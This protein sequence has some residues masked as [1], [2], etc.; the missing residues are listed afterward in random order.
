ENAQGENSAVIKI[1]EAED[2]NA[3]EP[4]FQGTL[5]LWNSYTADKLKVQ[6]TKQLTGDGPS[7]ASDED[8]VFSL[9]CKDPGSERTITAQ[10]TIRGAGN[11][12]FATA[13]APDQEAVEIPVGWSCMIKEDQINRYDADVKVSFEGATL[14][15][16]LTDTAGATAAFKIAGVPDSTQN[17]TVINDYARKR[18]QL[19]VATKYVGNQQGN[20]NEYLTNKET[21]GVSWR[22][23]DPLTDQVHE[24][25]L[26]VPADGKLIEIL[27][28]DGKQL[29]VSVECELTEDTSD[30]VPAEFADKV[31]STHRVYASIP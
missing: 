5:V 1:R 20:V 8:F 7:L 15:T 11:G 13:N 30:K 22:C 25:S 3:A 28:K 6:V 19:R 10:R 17:V 29:P 16:P 23:E 12:L 31:K 14:E 26:R 4:N 9:V 18:A 24:G 2:A 27:G 21:F